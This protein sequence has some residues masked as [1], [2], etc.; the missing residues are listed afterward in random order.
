MST[1]G[2]KSYTARITATQ[3]TVF[4]P[5][6][7]GSDAPRSGQNKPVRKDMMLRPVVSPNMRQGAQASALRFMGRCKTSVRIC[8]TATLFVWV[9]IW[10]SGKLSEAV[11]YRVQYRL[12]EPVPQSVSIYTPRKVS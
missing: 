12:G 6:P 5:S 10:P 11:T 9:E 1:P 7:F 3:L 4:P 2:L 8:D